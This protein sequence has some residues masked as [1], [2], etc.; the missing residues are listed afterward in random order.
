MNGGRVPDD[1][2][3]GMVGELGGGGPVDSAEPGGGAVPAPAWTGRLATHPDDP[4]ALVADRLVRGGASRTAA[5][6]PWSRLCPHTRR[7]QSSRGIPLLLQRGDTRVR[8]GL[9]V[10]VECGVEPNAISLCLHSRPAGRESS[11][12]R[13]SASFAA[14][15]P[16]ESPQASWRTPRSWLH[17]HPLPLRRKSACRRCLHFHAAI[18]ATPSLS[19]LPCSVGRFGSAGA[20]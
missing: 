12:S 7:P 18:S 15:S 4:A 10:L 1:E 14:D 20:H 3:R 8:G 2:L 6:P 19:M 13:H 11:G 9:D 17:G 5:A 16:Q